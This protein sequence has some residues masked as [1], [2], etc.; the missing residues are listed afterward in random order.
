MFSGIF[1]D[2]NY[3]TEVA[4]LWE[5]SHKIQTSVRS[6]SDKIQKKGKDY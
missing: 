3:R 1:I 4:D 5:N 2:L 6:K